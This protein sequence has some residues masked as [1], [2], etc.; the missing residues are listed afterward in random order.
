MIGYFILKNCNIRN[1][2]SLHYPNILQTIIVNQPAVLLNITPLIWILPI[3]RI[4]SLAVFK[5]DNISFLAYT[6]HLR[7]FTSIAAV[8]M[9]R[10]RNSQKENILLSASYKICNTKDIQA[11]QITLQL[12]RLIVKMR[13]IFTRTTQNP[14]TFLSNFDICI[15]WRWSLWTEKCCK[16]ISHAH[17]KQPLV[18]IDISVCLSLY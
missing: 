5:E 17:N 4:L 2:Q 13:S 18:V 14:V 7:T 6:L 1:Q 15:N 3:K 8:K 10:E 11:P 16:E 9:N 12:R